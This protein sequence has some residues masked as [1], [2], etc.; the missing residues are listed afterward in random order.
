MPRDVAN[1]NQELRSGTPTLAILAGGAASRMGKPKGELVIDGR[2]IIQYLLDRF[3]WDGPTLLVTAPGREYPPGWERFTREVVDPVSGQG[4]LRGVLTALENAMT[5]RVLVTTIDMPGLD[6]SHLRWMVEQSRAS[7]TMTRHGDQIEP[8]PSMYHTPA[9]AAMIRA[10]LDAGRLSVQALSRQA[11][12]QVLD[13]PQVWDDSVW[14]N[15]NR[16]QDL[17]DFLTRLSRSS[18]A[19]R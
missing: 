11:A 16:P 9:A 18:R 7:V 3:A 19:G 4:P 1:E 8:F 14:M 17:T 13:A 5:D 2:S 12:A 15:L 6:G 10:E